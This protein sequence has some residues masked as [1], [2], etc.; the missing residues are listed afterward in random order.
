MNL[1]HF[2]VNLPIMNKMKKVSHIF[3]LI[4]A[5]MLAACGEDRSNEYYELTKE[6]RWIYDNMKEAYLWK[7][8]I[9]DIAQQTYFNTSAQFFKKLLNKE[10]NVSFLTADDAVSYGIKY[11]LMRDPLGVSPSK[12]YALVEYVEPNSVAAAAGIERGMWISAIDGKGL[13]M[14]STTLGNGAALQLT[15]C[16]II[17]DASNEALMWSEGETYAVAAATQLATPALPISKT[18][19][20]GSKN[21][22]YI[23]LN[24]FDGQD[25]VE[26]LSSAVAEFDT[27]D[28]ILDLRFNESYNIGDA[29]TAAALFAPA[30]R[31]ESAF[32]TIYKDINFDTH[33][34]ILF[35]ASS[36]N[37]ADKNLYI[38][39]SGATK[40][41]ANIFIEAVKSVRDSNT[42]I[43]GTS[44]AKSDLLTEKRASPYGFSIHPATAI[45]ADAYGNLLQGITPDLPIDA[46]GAYDAIYPLGDEREYILHNICERIS[47]GN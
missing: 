20:C 34:R 8:E 5:L 1:K 13:Y 27:Q 22:T 10:D 25:A 30:N 37:V 12:V 21:A 4:T 26:S 36:I 7:N 47:T 18:I 32:C 43:A 31:A 19:V 35:P 23:L 40:G 9:G 3:A 17:Q 42:I 2:S 44:P 39:T 28:I 45:I 38:I 24:T 6:N 46:T 14:S 16:N 33:E 11:S 41:V 15:I 29:A